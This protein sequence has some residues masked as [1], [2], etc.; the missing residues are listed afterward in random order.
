MVDLGNIQSRF[1]VTDVQKSLKPPGCWR[2]CW[3]LAS[4]RFNLRPNDPVIGWDLITLISWYVQTLI[5][6]NVYKYS[7][8]FSAKRSLIFTN[9]KCHMILC[10]RIQKNKLQRSIFFDI[11]EPMNLKKKRSTNRSHWIVV[12]MNCYH[13]HHNKRNICKQI[14]FGMILQWCSIVPLPHPVRNHLFVNSTVG[15]PSVYCCSEVKDHRSTLR[16]PSSTTFQTCPQ[17]LHFRCP[18]CSWQPKPFWRTYSSHSAS[19]SYFVRR[20]YVI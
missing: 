11:V 4:S 2:Q 5:T 6:S 19:I 8:I 9:C 10:D 17:K 15:N 1:H 20:T 13:H 14:L 18:G 7:S 3:Q 12:L 16:T